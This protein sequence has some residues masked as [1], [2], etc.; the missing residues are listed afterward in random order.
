M[1]N[2][3][4]IEGRAVVLNTDTEVDFSGVSVGD[5]RPGQYQVFWSY[6]PSTQVGGITGTSWPPDMMT[7]WDLQ[8]ALKNL[9]ADDSNTIEAVSIIVYNYTSYLM[10]HGTG[11][12]WE[13]FRNTYRDAGCLRF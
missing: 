6:T 11:A 4:P 7:E 2:Y 1:S 12:E 9:S 10:E 13:S 3:Q 8:V 5:G